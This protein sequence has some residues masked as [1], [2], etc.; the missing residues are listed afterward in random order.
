[1]PGCA[2][3]RVRVGWICR[4]TA[5]LLCLALLEAI[6]AAAPVPAASPSP[7]AARDGMVVTE[8]PQASRV[9][10]EILAQGGN[11]VDAAIA[12]TFALAVSHPQA[13][14]IGGGGFM[15]I[16]MADGSATAVDF[17]EKA[18]GQATRDMFHQPS[19]WPAPSTSV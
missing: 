3:G 5:V 18:P 8:S 9:G 12:A 1:M 17:R 7:V 6:F 4:A 10:A 16:R 11:A 19:V 13:G 14:N 15:I 2:G